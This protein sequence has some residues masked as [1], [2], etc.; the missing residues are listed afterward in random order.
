MS[1]YVREVNERDFDQV[2]RSQS[3]ALVLVDFSAHGADRAGGRRAAASKYRADLKA[4][5]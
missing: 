4:K 3:K 5:R 1:E 2:S